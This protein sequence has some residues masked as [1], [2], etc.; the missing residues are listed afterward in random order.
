M[1]KKMTPYI[2]LKQGFSKEKYAV[3]QVLK[4]TNFVVL[5]ISQLCKSLKPLQGLKNMIGVC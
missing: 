4:T 2:D 1:R 5:N 3:E